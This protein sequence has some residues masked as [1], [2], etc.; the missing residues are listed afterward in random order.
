MEYIIKY[1]VTINNID[2]SDFIKL[3]SDIFKCDSII[4]IVESI[5]LN[6]DSI[7]IYYNGKVIFQ[8][9]KSLNRCLQIDRLRKTIIT[10]SKKEIA[11]TNVSDKDSSPVE[12]TS[13]ND[14]SQSD[15]YY[16]S[17][18]LKETMKDKYSKSVSSKELNED[19]NI[20]DIIRLEKL[21]EE[22]RELQRKI[23]ILTETV[24]SNNTCG[25]YP[26]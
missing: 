8:A 11:V 25:Q 7:I 5:W 21:R 14:L 6:V 18:I 23:N 24:S 13:C 1:E 19:E 22:N 2:K 4:D 3:D 26:K 16:K 15:K 12:E 10:K 9:F 20:K 17:I